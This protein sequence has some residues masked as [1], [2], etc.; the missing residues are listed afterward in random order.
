MSVRV[1]KKRTRRRNG[2]EAA[3]IEAGSL[4]PLSAAAEVAT[5]RIVT[6]VRET[7]V[8]ADKREDGSIVSRV[9]GMVEE[10]DA[11]GSPLSRRCAITFTVA[12]TAGTTHAAETSIHAVDP[13][14]IVGTG[15]SFAEKPL[16]LLQT[17]EWM[18]PPSFHRLAKK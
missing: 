11:G 7:D 1:S 17:K 14:S 3:K 5:Y 9:G 4:P 18:F 12:R 15:A 16:L 2:A 8:A 6:V 13:V 10:A